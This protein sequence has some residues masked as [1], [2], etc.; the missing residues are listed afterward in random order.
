VPKAAQNTTYGF[1][2]NFVVLDDSESRVTRGVLQ[3]E[4]NANVQAR[5]GLVSAT[6]NVEVGIAQT[7]PEVQTSS[8]GA[9]LQALEL[10][11]I[12]VG[13]H[14]SCGLTSLGEAYCWGSN[15]FGQLG[16]AGQDSNTSVA[17]V[18]G[19]RFSSISAGNS[20]TCGITVSGKAYCW[21]KNAE[22]RLGNATRQ[23]SSSPSPVAAN[24]N[25]EV[26]TF[27]QLSAGGEHTCG[28]NLQQDLYCWGSSAVLGVNSLLLIPKRF[29]AIPQELSF[30]QVSAGKNHTCALG[31]SKKAYCWGS[32]NFGQLG[33]NDINPRILP[34]PLAA[35][36]DHLTFSSI[37]SGQDHTCGLTTD[38]QAYCWG[39][40]NSGQLGVS[41][42]AES[43]NP[44]A[45]T[46]GI[47]NPVLRFTSLV[48]GY[49]FTCGL[50]L[51]GQLYCW[52]N[53]DYGQLGIGA[54]PST[55]VPTLVAAPA[56]GE[57]LL[58]SSI[59]VGESSSC[60]VT[61]NAQ[62]FCWGFNATGQLGNGTQDDSS[63]PVEVSRAHFGL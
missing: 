58:Y 20:H 26:L 28:I 57:Q 6:Q 35:P 63:L 36:G 14:H 50:T 55:A 19:H 59:A 54:L 2:M 41:G 44:I 25:G 31:V 53:N 37:S 24:G 62:M 3:Q 60:A 61:T 11:R 47:G 27:L 56:S 33:T 42:I 45:V 1:V 34:T 7:V 12:S 9:S 8:L 43:L 49:Y 46:F 22:G 4:T 51:A 52:G 21:G 13:G 48:V 17:V 23:N 5:V 30:T 16:N 15:N 40:N 10:G 38:G 39:R 18:G 29:Y 32:N